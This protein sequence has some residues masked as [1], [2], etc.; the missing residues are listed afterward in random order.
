VFAAYD[1]N[2]Q[3]GITEI[4]WISQPEANYFSDL[5][6]L[7]DKRS[8]VRFLLKAESGEDAV[9][10]D[11]AFAELKAIQEEIDQGLMQEDQRDFVLRRLRTPDLASA[12]RSFYL[13]LLGLVGESSDIQYLEPHVFPE[14]QVS[15]FVGPATAAYLRLGD[16]QA[17]R[18]LVKHYFDQPPPP[19]RSDSEKSAQTQRLYL[20]YNAIR[21]V[22]PELERQ[23]KLGEYLLKHSVWGDIVLL[24]ALS[25]SDTRFVDSAIQ[26][27]RREDAIQYSQEESVVY[28]AGILDCE[29]Q[30]NTRERIKRFIES[31]Q[32]T[33]PDLY[34]RSIKRLEGRRK[35]MSASE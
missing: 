3:L 32:A 9:V 30:A 4:Q 20:V 21:D 31:V 29:L 1:D 15:T 35:F 17:R 33:E 25:E 11:H 6:K 27:Y 14:N 8:R 12:R 23:A 18:K 2:R 7:T 13:L 26:Y 10:S 34:R 16:E 22:A 19:A 24:H 28:L 5:S